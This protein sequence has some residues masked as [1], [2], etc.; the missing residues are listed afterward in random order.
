MNIGIC[1]KLFLI[2]ILLLQIYPSLMA[3]APK[4]GTIK[5]YVK[6]N[7][8][9]KPLPWVNIMI[10]GTGYNRTKETGYT[11]RYTIPNIYLQYITQI[12]KWK[13]C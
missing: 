1:I 8:T 7:Q 6:D 5:G 12:C 4:K 2:N 13:S 9:N 11:R 10:D 3:Q